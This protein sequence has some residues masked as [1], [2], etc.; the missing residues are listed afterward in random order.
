[1]LIEKRSP[2]ELRFWVD[3]TN[4]RTNEAS[5]SWFISPYF[6]SRDDY[7]YT[8]KTSIRT[9]LTPVC[10]M[11]HGSTK[12]LPMPDNLPLRCCIKWL[13]FKIR[14]CS[15]CESSHMRSCS[16]AGTSK[17]S[18]SVD[19]TTVAKSFARASVS[20]VVIFGSKVCAIILF[21]KKYLRCWILLARNFSWSKSSDTF[22]GLW[23][24]NPSPI[25]RVSFVVLLRQ[26]RVYD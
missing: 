3:P 20:N 7:H 23:M 12:S 2:R 9:S 25:S 21:W 5:H 15:K 18:T 1:M 13:C 24:F 6:R 17:T 11:T 26:Y 14:H 16:T 10:N 19:N 8:F 4:G 22:R